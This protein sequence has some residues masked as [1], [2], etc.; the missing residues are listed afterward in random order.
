[1]NIVLDTY[2]LVSAVWSADNKPGYNV[3][4]VIAD[5]FTAYFDYRILEEYKR[6]LRRPIFGFTLWEA[7]Y[8]LEPIV[9]NGLSVIPEPLKNVVYR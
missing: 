8:L 6:V 4:A 7:D 9:R 3:N 5:Q 2:F 1:M